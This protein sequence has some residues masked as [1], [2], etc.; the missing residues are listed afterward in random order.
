MSL[1][2]KLFSGQINWETANSAQKLAALDELPSNDPVLGQLALGEPDA[3][4]R[5]KA[6]GVMEAA[7]QLQIASSVR[8]GDENC[9]AASLGERIGE[10]G[11][12][13]DEA[14]GALASATAGF[15]IALIAHAKSEPL[16]LALTASLASDAQRAKIARGKGLIDARI[17]AVGG[18]SEVD[19]LESIAQEFRDKQRGIYRA[20]R[21]RAD[22]LLA[23]RETQRKALELCERLSGL[24]ERHELTLSAFTLVEREWTALVPS[25]ALDA[26]EF[27]ATQARYATLKDQARGLLQSQSEVLRD[28]ERLKTSLADLAARSE[29]D[30]AVEPESLAALVAEREAAA[31]RLAHPGLAALPKEREPIAERIARIAER[32]AI[33]AVESAALVNARKLVEDLRA[34][35]AVLTPAWRT[36]YARQSAI[37]RTSLRAPIEEAATALRSVIDTAAREKADAERSVEQ[38]H[39]AEIEALIKLMEQLLDKGQHQQANDT[40]ATL[41]EKRSQTTNARPLPAAME[42]RLKRCQDRLAKMNEW[43]RF[44]DA[45]AREALCREAEALAKRVARQQKALIA[46]TTPQADAAVVDTTDANAAVVDTAMVAAPVDDA[47][48]DE[49]AVDDTIGMNEATAP[50]VEAATASLVQTPAEPSDETVPVPVADS[51]DTDA[52]PQATSESTTAETPVA[53][54]GT[55]PTAEAPTEV[56]VEVEAVST[57][58]EPE[59][60]TA[61]ESAAAEAA[62]AALPPLAPEVVAAA[63]RDIQARWAKLDK[64]QG[65]TSKGLHGRFRRACDRAYAPAKKH[66]EELE[67]QREANAEKKNAVME[68]IAALNERIAEGAEWGKILS[69]RGELVKTWFDAG[70]LPR[71]DAKAMQ[72]RFD[73]L[74]KEIDR[75]LD[76][77]RAAERAR[78]REMIDRAR[79]IAER[80]AEGGSIAAMIALQKQWQET[81][82]G[83]I[84][85]RAKEDQTLWEEFR[86]AG[87]AL[88]GKRDAEKAALSNERDA[89][90]AA[91]RVLVEEMQS[92]A[93]GSDA[94]AV[95]RAIDDIGSRWN[96]MEWPDRKPLRQWEQNFSNA[97]SAASARIAELRGEAE[98]GQRAAAA[99]RLA[100]VERAEQALGDGTVPDMDAV[101]A[102]VQAMLA[103]GEK[104]DARVT[105]R[106]ASL[107]AAAKAGPDAW[108]AKSEKTRIER[109]ALLL[110][111]EIVLDLPSPPQLEGERRMRLLKRLAESKN[112][113]STP[114]LAA[115]DAAK[116]VEKLLALPL[117]MQDVHARVDAVIEAARRKS[118]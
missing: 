74:T 9:L 65:P 55:A 84:R 63:V 34:D 50:A 19:L 48:V 1:F 98:K 58:T 104:P 72:K 99:A 42:F 49:S 118:K 75:K 78:R 46:K 70:P 117:A 57:A 60:Q 92:L 82:K 69:Q 113:R 25:P 73:A 111:L 103:D 7:A 76:A 38:G 107:E 87:N 71:K 8:T 67:K 16:A 13:V 31:A 59:T 105:A 56:E 32:H 81:M 88:F 52:L 106:L 95:R 26:E 40:M 29:A 43:K 35:P 94:A 6:I 109:D 61:A 108:R 114:P 93:S 37:V 68:K 15:R 51:P 18:I 64:S 4:V 5:H 27:A 33:L 21:D 36:D 90:V 2:S 91:R 11:I 97:R 45:Q 83:A 10:G 28:A 101:R 39:R 89:Q 41:V 54:D 20:A 96:T 22:A 110:E 77:Q 66:F 53:S 12:A 86:A 85:L 14:L 17:T 23:A 102:E 116:A 112:S 3:A 24:L 80:T 79:A 115:A 30:A 47:A 62:E 100:V 44:G